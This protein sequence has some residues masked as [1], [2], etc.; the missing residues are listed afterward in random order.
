LGKSKT[1]ELIKTGK[2]AEFVIAAVPRHALLELVGWEVIHQLGEDEA[3]DVHASLSDPSRG[4]LQGGQ[5]FGA[6]EK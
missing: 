1:K 5:N 6:R 3:A 2:A 4:G